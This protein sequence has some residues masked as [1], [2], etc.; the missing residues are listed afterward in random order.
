LQNDEYCALIAEIR[1]VEMGF[2][3]LGF[4]SLKN[5]KN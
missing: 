1:V 3:N 2:K 4:R 5:L